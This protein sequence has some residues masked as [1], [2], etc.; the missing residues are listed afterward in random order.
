MLFRSQIKLDQSWGSDQFVVTMKQHLTYTSAALSNDPVGCVARV[1]NALEGI[2]EKI[3]AHQTYLVTLEKELV[4][5]REEAERPFPKED[6]LRQKSA[7]LAQLDRELEKPRKKTAE[8]DGG[9]DADDGGAP[10][11]EPSSPSVPQG[12]KPSIRQALRDHIPPAPVHPSSDR[13]QRREAA[14]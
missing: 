7:R 6:E 5:A 3:D 8:R 9:P 2:P 13:S 1:N 11:R 10:A 12:D 14:L 4:N